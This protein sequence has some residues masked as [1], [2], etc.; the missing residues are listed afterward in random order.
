V[1]RLLME[2]L[3]SNLHCADCMA[4]DRGRVYKW[5]VWNRQ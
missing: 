2:M 1:L 5:L 3:E 4:S